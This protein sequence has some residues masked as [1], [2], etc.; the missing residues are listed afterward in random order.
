MIVSPRPVAALVPAL[1]IAAALA[2]AATAWADEPEAITTAPP[3]SAGAPPVAGP[4]PAITSAAP[5]AATPGVGT[6]SV[7]D[8]IDNY[9]KTSPALAPPRDDASG[10]TS[11]D[12]P[13]K[14]HGM[15]DVAVGSNGYRSAFVQS[16]LPVG[17]TGTLSIAVGESRFNGN[18]FAGRYGGPFVGGPFV[19]GERQSL[20]LGLYLGGADARSQDPRCRRA[21]GYA[22]DMS[23]DPRIESGRLR[24]CRTA[25]AP[26]SPP[27]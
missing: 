9:L 7:A 12:A 17:K 5:A 8:Q 2:A 24:P 13:R 23:G 14:V 21:W 11:G 25:E 6:T 20:A 10:V 19:G 1:I 3:A 26:T 27:Q 22:S 15:A 18:R 16:D 4:A